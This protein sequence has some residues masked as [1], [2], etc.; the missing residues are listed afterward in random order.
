MRLAPSSEQFTSRLRS[1]HVAARVGLWL[2]VC[3]GICFVTGLV[4]HYAQEYQ[5]PVPFPTSPAWGYRLTQGL[6]VVTG[7]ATIPL[8]LVKLWTVY[9]NLFAG[10]PRR[11]LGRMAVTAAERA[12][13][14]VLVASAIFLL[15]TGLVNTTRWYP[16]EFSFRSTHYALAW[17]GIGAL[18][19]HIAVKLPV[20]RD[21]LLGDVDDDDHDRPSATSEGSLSR[22][23]LLRTTWVAAGVTVLATAGATVPWLRQVSVL[24]V[25]SGE[26]PAGIPINRTAESARITDAMVG[27]D[28][29]LTVAA[30]G[31]ETVFGRK[32][33]VALPQRTERL[34]IACV[35][36]WSATG[37]WTGVRLRDL[38]DAAGAAPGSDVIVRSMQERG[39][40]TVTRLP[41]NFVDDPRTLV[42]LQL[43][44]RELDLDHGYPCRLIAPNRPGVLQT[45]WLQRLEVQA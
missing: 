33:L 40:F 15:A 44:G 17:V 31:A 4:S 12:S 38:L 26:G 6:H 25:R 22:R 19:V 41:A 13:I 27:P 9:P 7:T 24:A 2:G 29:R 20:I 45:K 34:P 16:W 36:G 39:P 14:A 18:V 42:A 23:G 10:F 43:A 37:D 3:F 5:Q 35:E 8:L 11:G 32:D 21:V 30:G 1:A 28:Y